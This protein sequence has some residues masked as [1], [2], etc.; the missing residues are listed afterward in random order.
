[1]IIVSESLANQ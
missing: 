1:M